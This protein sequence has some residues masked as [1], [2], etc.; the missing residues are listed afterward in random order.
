M[1]PPSVLSSATGQKLPD[2]LFYVIAR[3]FISSLG[4]IAR[5]SRTNSRLFGLL[6]NELY[7]SELRYITQIE[8]NLIARLVPDPEVAFDVDDIPTSRADQLPR[9][10]QH[11]Q[12][13]NLPRTSLHFAAANGYVRVAKAAIKTALQIRPM[14]LDSKDQVGRT[15]LAV[16]STSG[17]IE[18]VRELVDAGALLYAPIDEVHPGVLGHPTNA[19][20]LAILSQQERVACL[21]AQQV[22][23]LDCWLAKVR[24]TEMA[25]EHAAQMGM[26]R[27]IKIIL[28]HKHYVSEWRGRNSPL[29]KALQA[30][31]TNEENF[32]AIDMLLQH[33]VWL[34]S[35]HERWMTAI[36]WAVSKR[37][38][39]N[40]VF[41]VRSY[42]PSMLEG[43]HLTGALDVCCNMDEDL[44]CA[45][46]LVKLLNEQGRLS[47]IQEQ[48]V[49]C[50]Q[51]S[52][53]QGKKEK[54]KEYLT[55]F[56]ATKLNPSYLGEGRGYLHWALCQQHN[57]QYTPL[58]YVLSQ[59][60]EM[61]Q[62]NAKDAMGCTPLDYAIRNG[63]IEIARILREE[64]GAVESSDGGF[65]LDCLF[66]ND[67]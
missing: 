32:E 58:K 41:L 53:P 60:G 16:A 35:V 59:A 52:R 10:S 62:V 31:L 56:M 47:A 3:D 14:Y 57:V 34:G 36:Y 28:S 4:D 19:L 24:Y 17:N 6:Q 7:R 2:E 11:M 64:H 44:P 26:H 65:G 8:L 45:M 49:E 15:P 39:R 37:C 63:H 30:A 22:S 27:V 54:I 50:L 9:L 5:L 12:R 66:D 51:K 1:A 13:P 29:V 20:S 25:L 23:R 33:G 55:K 61:L 42:Y 48:L 67:A 18:V 38:I 43:Q 40:A 21:L 46:E